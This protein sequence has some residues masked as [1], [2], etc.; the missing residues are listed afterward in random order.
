MDKE[1]KLKYI[2]E[3]K[4]LPDEE[5]YLLEQHRKYHSNIIFLVV[6]LFAIFQLPVMITTRVIDNGISI[7]GLP[8]TWSA[9]FMW[10]YFTILTEVKLLILVLASHFSYILFNKDYNKAKEIKKKIKDKVEGMKK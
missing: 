3:L 6:L 8:I 4:K 1:K 9:F 2:R 7:F 10:A 5:F